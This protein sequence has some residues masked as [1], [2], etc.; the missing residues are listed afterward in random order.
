LERVRDAG[1]QVAAPGVRVAAGGET[2]EGVDANRAIQDALPWVLA[3][4]LVVIYVVLLV[5]F[6]SVFLPLK[7]ILMNLLSVGATYGALVLVFQHGVGAALLGDPQ[8][9][10]VQNF[11]PILL[12]AILFSLSTDYEVFLLNRIR[13]EH[14]AGAGETESVAAGLAR[15]APLITGAAVLMIAVFGAF[16]FTGI[17]PIQQL[18]FG[19]A[20][21]IA[22]DATVIRL[23]V[24]PAS[25]RL[26]G[27]WN[28]WL[29]GRPRPGGPR[30][31]APAA[32]PAGA[33]PE[34]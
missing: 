19:L 32:T 23:V 33:L 12:L 7:A 10:H 27:G 16:T 24:V 30:P 17:M 31:P 14:E 9:G 11:V 20:V 1:R 6:R 25:M 26:M 2:A 34:R 8:T 4:M 5:T 13:E 15:T 3:V 18:G 21:A 29:P 28:W 22:L